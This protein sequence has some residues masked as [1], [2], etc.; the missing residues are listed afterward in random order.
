MHLDISIAF[1]SY[2]SHIFG[3]SHCPLIHA[4]WDMLYP[5]CVWSSRDVESPFIVEERCQKTTGPR[6]IPHYF[7]SK[8]LGSC[9]AGYSLIVP[10]ILQRHCG[11]PLSKLCLVALI[12][13]KDGASMV[14]EFR[15]I[16]LRN[17]IFK[18]ISKVLANWLCHHIHLLVDQVQSAFTRNRCILDSVACAQEILAAS[19][20]SNIMVIFL[21]LDF[22]KAFD[23]IS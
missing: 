10:S 9:Q 7:L 18:I 13:K 20:N 21:N 6:W 11:S 15:P 16:S 3:A 4:N 17:A 14:N 19:H 23:S 1:T 22:E 5:T 12:P 8:I 2:F